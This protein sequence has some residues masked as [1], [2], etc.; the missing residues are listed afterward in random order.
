M[1]ATLLTVICLIF[2]LEGALI[3][4]N[5]NDFK[6]GDLFYAIP[7]HICPTVAKYSKAYTVK[8]G[9]VGPFWEIEARDYQV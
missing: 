7:Y 9:E 3:K 2:S 8:E 1:L 6:V 5:P 4:N